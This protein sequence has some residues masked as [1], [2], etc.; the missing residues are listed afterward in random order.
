[1]KCP[2]T[3][4]YNFNGRAPRGVSP[5]MGPLLNLTREGNRTPS[6]RSSLSLTLQD[7]QEQQQVRERL[8]EQPLCLGCYQPGHFV[9][10]CT[11]P[12]MNGVPAGYQAPPKERERE[13]RRDG[14]RFPSR[15]RLRRGPMGGDTPLGALPLELD[16]G[17]GGHFTRPP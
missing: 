8:Q 13:L 2:P 16:K 15:V 10:D 6:L 7:L 14:M 11:S 5:P 3:P 17:V 4:L 12:V 9:A 1:M